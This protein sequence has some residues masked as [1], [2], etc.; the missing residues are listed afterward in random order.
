MMTL[1]DLPP[2]VLKQLRDA[3]LTRDS[4]ETILKYLYVPPKQP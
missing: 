4:V 3:P 2:E 1:K